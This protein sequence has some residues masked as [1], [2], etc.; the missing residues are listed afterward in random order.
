MY[1]KSQHMDELVLWGQRHT[2]QAAIL[3]NNW[4]KMWGKQ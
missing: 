1:K 4:Q 3:W 2:R